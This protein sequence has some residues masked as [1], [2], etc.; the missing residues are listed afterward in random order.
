MIRRMKHRLFAWY[1]VAATLLAPIV[2]LAKDE[3]DE[4]LLEARM[5]GY[6][7][8][9]RLPPASTTLTWF[10][11]AFLAVLLVASLLKNAKRTHL[12]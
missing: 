1:F 11:I 4:A 8:D 3:E 6:A 5:E 2:A 7:T 10:L 9:V 12:D